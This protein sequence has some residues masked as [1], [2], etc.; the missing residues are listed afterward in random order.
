MT[1]KLHNSSAKA[2]WKGA[3][4]EISVA[5]YELLWWGSAQLLGFNMQAKNAP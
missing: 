1:H 3:W 4:M 5:K 2:Q